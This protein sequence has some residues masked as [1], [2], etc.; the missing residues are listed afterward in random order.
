MLHLGKHL[1]KQRIYVVLLGQNILLCPC[2]GRHEKSPWCVDEP[3][4]A[5]VAPEAHHAQ[6]RSSHRVE[7]CIQPVR[8][9]PCRNVTESFWV[10]C[11]HLQDPALKGRGHRIGEHHLLHP[12]PVQIGTLL[13]LQTGEK[14]VIMDIACP[15]SI[16]I[17]P[18]RTLLHVIGDG[19]APGQVLDHGK[20]IRVG[21]HT[22]ITAIHTAAGQGLAM[23]HRCAQQGCQKEEN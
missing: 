6:L 22:V 12:V 2:K 23:G 10:L 17:A 4:R 20:K 8:L 11:D 21:D 7:I 19:V 1:E 13:L 18:T 9:R 14:N 5:V 3:R 16:Q 15:V